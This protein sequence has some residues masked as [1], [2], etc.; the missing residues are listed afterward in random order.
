DFVSTGT[1]VTT[2]G[3]TGY[4]FKALDYGGMLVVLVGSAKYIIPRDSDIDGMPDAWENLYGNL[5]PDADVDPGPG[6][7]GAVGDGIANLDEYRGFIVSGTHVRM[8]PSVKNVFVHLVNPQ[9][10]AGSATSYL[11]GGAVTYVPFEELFNNAD[12]LISG[13]RL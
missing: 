9:C 4:G 2:P 5:A 7:N 6:G 8:H 11:G 1:T 10:V 13:T 3:G 12:T